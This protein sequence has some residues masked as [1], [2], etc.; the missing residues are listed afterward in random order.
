MKEF[1][2]EKLKFDIN[3]CQK[4]RFHMERLTLLHLHLTQMK[5]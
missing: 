5:F 3:F 1:D 4:Y 2:K